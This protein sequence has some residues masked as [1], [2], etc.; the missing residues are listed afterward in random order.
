MK[1]D[2]PVRTLL[3]ECYKLGSTVPGTRNNHYFEPV[4]TTEIRGK[5]VSVDPEFYVYHSFSQSEENQHNQI[6]KPLKKMD[7]IT[8]QYD[9]FWWFALIDDE[10][11]S[12][13]KL[14]AEVLEESYGEGYEF[15]GFTAEEIEGNNGS[16][17]IDFTI[18]RDG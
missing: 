7:Y 10:V 13:V 9:N 5:H 6:I 8:C 16:S 18:N 4:S 1:D 3:G 11:D 2:I 14:R 12:N 15:F 17:E